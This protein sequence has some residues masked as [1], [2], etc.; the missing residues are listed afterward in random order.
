M[1][2][3][4]VVRRPCVGCWMFAVHHKPPEYISPPA[5]RSGWSGGTLDK[6]W[7][8]PSTIEPPQ[9]PIFDQPSLSRPHS[10]GI[11]ATERSRYGVGLWPAGAWSHRLC[12]ICSAKLDVRVALSGHSQLLIAICIRPG[13]ALGGFAVVAPTGCSRLD[14]GCWMFW[15][16]TPQICVISTRSPL[17]ALVP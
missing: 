10:C 13:V 4:P 9:P 2:S 16:D 5:P 3:G 17:S 6:P 12:V 14:V 7:T 8:C 11:S 1:V 15:S